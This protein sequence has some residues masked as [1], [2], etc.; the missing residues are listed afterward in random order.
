M[1][2]K[3]GFMAVSEANKIDVNFLYVSDT[4]NEMKCS[5]EVLRL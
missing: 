5:L 3:G 2:T 4:L 1:M